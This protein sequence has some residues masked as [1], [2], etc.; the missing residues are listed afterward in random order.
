MKQTRLTAAERDDVYSTIS[1]KVTNVGASQE[2]LYLAR[3]VLL[4]AETIGDKAHI[5]RLLQEAGEGMVRGAYDGP[6]TGSY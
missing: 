1:Q 4:M 6:K 2:S 5:L 3:L